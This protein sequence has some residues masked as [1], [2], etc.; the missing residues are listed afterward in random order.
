LYDVIDHY[1]S[2]VFVKGMID[3]FEVGMCQ[4]QPFKLFERQTICT[5]QNHGILHAYRAWIGKGEGFLY[6]YKILP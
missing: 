5:T 1:L 4:R 3:M 2:V 6:Q